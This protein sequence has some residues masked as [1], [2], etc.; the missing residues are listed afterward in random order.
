MM[1]SITMRH[2]HW[3]LSGFGAPYATEQVWEENMK[4]KMLASKADRHWLYK[5]LEGRGLTRISSYICLLKHFEFVLLHINGKFLVCKLRSKLKAN[6]M[7]GPF[8]S[9]NVAKKLC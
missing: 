2:K 1:E 6:L 4:A 5:R 9:N 3:D 7:P 8:A